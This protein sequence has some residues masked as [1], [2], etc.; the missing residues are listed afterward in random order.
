MNW[1]HL[2]WIIPLTAI[3][4]FIFGALAN[5]AATWERALWYISMNCN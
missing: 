1:K 3:L 4:F 5:D 2:F